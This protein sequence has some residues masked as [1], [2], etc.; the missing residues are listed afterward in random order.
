MHSL[1]CL[2]GAQRGSRR[3]QVV[4]VE[5]RSV[6]EAQQGSKFR[7]RKALEAAKKAAQV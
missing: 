2:T 6:S 1:Q 7:A 5:A 3:S 4:D